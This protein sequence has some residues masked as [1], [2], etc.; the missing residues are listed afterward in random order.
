[1]G[2]RRLATQPAMGSVISERV[3]PSP[4]EQFFGDSWPRTQ[5]RVQSALGSGV[6]V[7]P[8]GLIGLRLFS[9][10]A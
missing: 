4:L 6:I 3:L 10:Q 1:M 7:R 8:D 5:Q 2:L 9:A